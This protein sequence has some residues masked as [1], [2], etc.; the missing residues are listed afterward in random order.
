MNPCVNV[1]SVAEKSLLGAVKGGV[2]GGVKG[3]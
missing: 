2:K 3:V 1:L